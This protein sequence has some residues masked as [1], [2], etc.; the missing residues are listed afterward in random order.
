MSESVLMIESVQGECCV[1]GKM[2]G[3]HQNSSQIHSFGPTLLKLRK[4]HDMGFVENFP[5]FQPHRTETWVTGIPSLAAIS[6]W[7][8]VSDRMRFWKSAGKAHS[9]QA[10]SFQNHRIKLKFCTHVYKLCTVI[11]TKFGVNQTRNKTRG[12]RSWRGQPNIR[13]LYLS[14]DLIHWPICWPI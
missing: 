6:S 2:V 9:F 5:K 4:S 3:M 10:R 7:C 11:C 8:I 12:L 1:P 13:Q 14:I